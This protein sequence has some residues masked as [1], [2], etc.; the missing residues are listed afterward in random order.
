MKEAVIINGALSE[1]IGAVPLEDFSR[2]K[3]KVIMI[4]TLKGLV[5]DTDKATLKAIVRE[6]E[7]D[8]TV[9]TLKHALEMIVEQAIKRV[10]T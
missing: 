9:K 8:L 7:A 3:E 2:F 4:N 6:T 5:T 10:T 1:D